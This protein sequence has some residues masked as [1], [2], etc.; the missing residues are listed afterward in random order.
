MEIKKV[1]DLIIVNK[2]GIYGLGLSAEPY[3]GKVRYLRITDIDDAGNLLD[4]DKKSVTTLHENDYF[5]QQDDLV[6]ARTGN[7]TGRTYVYDKSEG[8]MVYAGFLIK[9]VFDKNKINPRYLKY[10][11]I[12]SIY[13][14]QTAK[15]SGSTRGN[16]SAQD[17]KNIKIV[18][19]NRTTQDKMVVLFDFINKKMINNNKINAELESM[20]KTLYDYW[21][22]QYEFPNEQGKPYKSS[23]GKL[24]WNEEFKR[25]I[26]EKW[27]VNKIANCLIHINTGLNPRDHFVLNDGNIKYITVKNLTTT[28]ELDFSACDTISNNTKELINKRSMISQGDILFASIAPLGRCFIIRETPNNLEINESV[29]SIRPNHKVSSEYLYQY[30]MSDYFVKK[31]EHSSTG[32]VFAGIRITTLNDMDIVTPP[33]VILDKFTKYLTNLYKLKHIKSKE[34]QELSSVRDFLLPLLMN[35]QVTFI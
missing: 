29:F 31:A 22:L 34:N 23:G 15:Y 20:A 5:L 33:K 9:Y 12:T 18:L 32:S 8:P 13:R 1:G 35:G 14:N 24:V 30:F 17:F 3:N 6:V 19:P 2:S 27:E 25:E 11:T 28:G 4:Q 21:F 7:S 10:F 26:P 16:M